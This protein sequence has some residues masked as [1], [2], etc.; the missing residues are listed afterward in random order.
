MAKILS[1]KI[2]SL[3]NQQIQ[4]EL[5]NSLVYLAMSN[6]FNYN[7]WFGGSK[8]YKT[9][10]D[11]EIIHRDKFIKYML[12]MDSMPIIP[13]STFDTIVNDFKDVKEILQKS[14]DREISTTD[15]IKS[16]KEVAFTEKDFVT[17][18][19][20][21]WFLLEQIEELNKTQALLD[22]ID[23]MEKY[24]TPLYHLDKDMEELIG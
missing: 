3:I 19:F 20:L 10:S 23:M 17:A 24:N 9:Y 12:D 11:D 5:T 15:S 16:I 4:K 21:D 13:S 1:T 6:W 8:L 7:G 2:E 18:D 22:R 14:Y